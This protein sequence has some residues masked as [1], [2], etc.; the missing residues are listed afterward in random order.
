VAWDIEVTEEFKEWWNSLT[1]PEQISV[2]RAVLLLEDRGPNLPYPFSSKVSSSRHPAMRELRIQ[3][4][5]RPYRVLY[6]FD[7]RRIA[8][9]L[10]CGDKTGDDRWYEKSMPLAD[11]LC[12]NHLMELEEENRAKNDEVQ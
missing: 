9:L 10:L 11:Q 5:S 4:Q 7:P 6:I 3:R 1:E 12:A 8:I 2:E